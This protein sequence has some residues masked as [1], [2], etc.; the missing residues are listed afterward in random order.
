V[1]LLNTE[2]S[3]PEDGHLQPNYFVNY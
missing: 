3:Q 1:G 2:I